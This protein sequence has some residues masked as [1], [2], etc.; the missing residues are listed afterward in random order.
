MQE[1]IVI[2]PNESQEADV[3]VLQG[4]YLFTYAS[5]LRAGYVWFHAAHHLTR[6]LSFS[7]DHAILYDK[8]YTTLLEMI[9][10]AIERGIG[11]SGPHVACPMQLMVAAT[12][13]VTCYPSPA[14]LSSTAVAAAGHELVCDMIK[15][16][17][18]MN[19]CL[20]DSGGLT[21]GLSD[22]LAADANT[23]EGFVYLLKQRTLTEMGS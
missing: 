12:Q 23:L 19:Q 17:E 15:F 1:I 7:G 20:E 8:I 4:K 16:I 9:D 13:I 11:L 10:A 5:Y 6:G 3:A 18:Q 21:L 22:L 14:D 2:T